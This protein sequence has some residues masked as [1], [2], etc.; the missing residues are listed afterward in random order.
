MH[1]VCSESPGQPCSPSHTELLLHPSSRNER[2]I[3]SFHRSRSSKM[4]CFVVVFF[5]VRNSFLPLNNPMLRNQ[6]VDSQSGCGFG[7]RVL[8]VWASSISSMVTWFLG[9]CVCHWC[10]P[11][12]LGLGR[13]GGRRTVAGF[14]LPGT[15]EV[16]H[17]ESGGSHGTQWSG[18]WLRMECWKQYLFSKGTHLW[19]RGTI[20]AMP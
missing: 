18:W 15:C 14:S 2:E 3:T 12:S 20:L 6:T 13:F 8:R 16:R 1:L 17:G 11:M 4:L 7:R 19:W 9:M 10:G 5:L